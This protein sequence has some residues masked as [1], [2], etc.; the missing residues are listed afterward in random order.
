MR[1]KEENV[2][3]QCKLSRCC[4]TKR[5]YVNIMITN[6]EIANTSELIFRDFILT[7]Y[8][9]TVNN[10]KDNTNNKYDLNTPIIDKDRSFAY[11]I[12]PIMSV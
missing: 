12:L 8:K 11:R 2:G 1:N 5:S 6:I 7:L 9:W 10:I 3:K 4:I